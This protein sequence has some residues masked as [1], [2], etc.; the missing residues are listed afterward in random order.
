MALVLRALM[1][2]GGDPVLFGPTHVL[3]LGAATLAVVLDAGRRREDLFLGTLGVARSGIAGWGLVG[4][5]LG[6]G[7]FAGLVAL[8]QRAPP[9]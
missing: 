4:A 9:P 8:A 5:V 2:F 1:V 6:D 7:L 3:L